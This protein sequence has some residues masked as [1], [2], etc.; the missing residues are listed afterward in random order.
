MPEIGL[1]G[2]EKPDFKP[3]G[4]VK[5]LVQECVGGPELMQRKAKLQT[6]SESVSSSLKKHVFENYM[7]F[8][9]TAREISR[10]YPFLSLFQQ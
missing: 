10:E 7:Q 4:F 6:I 2:F 1:K 8:I 3:D 5:E 9:E